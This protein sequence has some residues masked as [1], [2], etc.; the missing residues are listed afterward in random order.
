MIGLEWWSWPES[1]AA[2]IRCSA[3]ESVSYWLLWWMTGLVPLPYD[4]TPCGAQV[5]D[6]A[7]R[8]VVGA[9]LFSGGA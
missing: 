5:A 7:G 1:L 8:C 2:V 3:V 6:G 9:Q 4:G